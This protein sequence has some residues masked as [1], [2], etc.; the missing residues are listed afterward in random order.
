MFLRPK[1]SPEPQDTLNLKKRNTMKEAWIYTNLS[2]VEQ[3]TAIYKH[4]NYNTIHTQRHNR[5]NYT[6]NGGMWMDRKYPTR[7]EIYLPDIYD[8]IHYDALKLN[9]NQVQYGTD[10]ASER[11]DEKDAQERKLNS[12]APHSAVHT[13]SEQEA[14]NE[15]TKERYKHNQQR[16]MS[17][18]RA[19]QAKRGT[20]TH[21]K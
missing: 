1:E 5:E 4:G 3:N 12:Q 7:P 13:T 16:V 14:P 8:G 15:N 10:N 18:Q 9:E 11:L 19:G 20:R 17:N 21:D 6:P 2:G